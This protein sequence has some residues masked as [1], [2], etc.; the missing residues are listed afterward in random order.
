MTEVKKLDRMV[1]INLEARIWTGLR[2][3]KSEDLRVSA[4]EIPPADLASLGSKRIVDPKEI[5][6]FRKLKAKAD[7]IVGSV[8]VPFLKGWAI[9]EDQF[10]EVTQA[11]E[12][13]RDEFEE[14]KADFLRRYD[15]VVEAWIAAHPEW[16]TI[17]RA[18]VTDRKHIDRALGFRWQSFRVVAAAAS[19]DSDDGLEQEAESMSSRLFKDVQDLAERTWQESYEGKV[20]VSQRALNPLRSIIKKLR[21]LEFLHPAVTPV[22]NDIEKAIAN[23]PSKGAIEGAK[24]HHLQSLFHLLTDAGRMM[25]HGQALVDGDQGPAVDDA[26]DDAS[27]S[28]SLN[29]HSPEGE[30]LDGEVAV[31]GDDEPVDPAP[32][33]EGVSDAE[34][35]E[36]E[37]TEAIETQPSEARSDRE[38][39]L[40]DP[41]AWF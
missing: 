41:D 15:D 19:G 3:L 4:G 38:P 9:S 24:L 12:G 39:A 13:V 29:E 36:P 6:V 16:E 37:R 11:L 22:A 32:E 34:S 25:R 14:A 35:S 40:A 26:D 20:S 28:A 33:G 18:S 1:V 17:I 23:A 27:I 8:G 21:S 10:T 5:A 30:A 7:R 31:D 2:R